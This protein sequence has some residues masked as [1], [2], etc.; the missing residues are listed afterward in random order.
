MRS[1]AATCRASSPG[2][3]CGASCSPNPPQAPTSPVSRPGRSRCR[4]AGS[5]TARR[6]GRRSP[7][8]PTSASCW[9]APIRPQPSTPVSRCSSSTSP[10]RAWRSARSANWTARLHFDEVFL[11]DVFVPSD[12]VLPPA[13]AGWR[14]ASAMLHHQR[15][16]RATGQRGGVRHDRTD[17]LRDECRRRALT[18]PVVRDEP[19]APVHRRGLPELARLQIAVGRLGAGGRSRSDRFA[20]QA[21]Q[22]PRRPPVR[23]PGMAD[24]R[25]RRAGL[26]R[27]ATRP[28]RGRS[29]QERNGQPTRCSRCRCPSPAVRTRSSDRSSPNECSDSPGNP[30]SRIRPAQP[31]ALSGRSGSRR[32]DRSRCAR[33]GSGWRG[34]RPTTTGTPTSTARRRRRRARRTWSGDGSVASSSSSSPGPANAGFRSRSSPRRLVARRCS[35]D[36]T[37][38]RFS[39]ARPST[40]AWSGLRATATDP[41]RKNALFEPGLAI[42]RA[43]SRSRRCGRVGIVGVVDEHDRVRRLHPDDGDDR[44]ERIEAGVDRARRPRRLVDVLGEAH[45]ELAAVPEQRHV[46]D[47]RPGAADVQQAQPHGP[48]DRRVGPVAR[49][50]RA[51]AAGDPARLGERAA[52]DDERRRR[53]RRALGLEQVVLGTQ[54]RPQR[55]D[56]DRHVVG[57]AARHH[58]VDRHLLDRR[59]RVRAGPSRRGSSSGPRPPPAPCARRAPASGSR[60]AGRRCS[61]AGAAP[62]GRRPRRG[63]AAAGS[64]RTRPARCRRRPR[65]AARR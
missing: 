49:A 38:E 2:A 16:A 60:P 53:V 32:P 5:S 12:S 13:G 45:R 37:S 9:P 52:D 50:E 47:A 57:V 20:R 39:P 54:Q 58:R 41:V 17:R 18:E 3:R 10:R 40:A 1:D 24:R 30:P 42:A 43:T 34:R 33:G 15:I 35:S 26:G 55:R 23:R 21:H 44:V 59:G 25:R 62:P 51:E 31:A 22:C 27:T 36:C 7:T 65:R 29:N 48:P 64:R 61:R 56:D 14:I 8:A 19:R 46:G 6:S 63:R 28:A 11:T 4:A